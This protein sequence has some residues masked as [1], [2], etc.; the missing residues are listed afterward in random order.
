MLQEENREG[1]HTR[2]ASSINKSIFRYRKLRSQDEPQRL[3]NERQHSQ[4][5]KP[6][7]MADFTNRKYR[8][9]TNIRQW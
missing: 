7:T 9:S 5:Q 8:P 3:Q 6:F 4:S 2:H 1:G